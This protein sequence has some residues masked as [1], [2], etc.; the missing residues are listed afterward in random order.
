ME[1]TAAKQIFD[2]LLEVSGSGVSVKMKSR[3]PGGRNVG[4][5]YSMSDHSVTIYL[6]EIKKQCMTLFGSLDGYGQLLR[7][8]FAHE[9]GHAEDAA[10]AD[11]SDR[12]DTCESELERKEI[13]LRIEENAW[14]YALKL[15]PDA[16][17]QMMDT[18]IYYSLH[19]YREAI[20]QET[21]QEIA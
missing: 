3:F 16:D 11:L 1:R 7:I 18:V 10:L 19:A 20:A 13:A 2:E 4:G 6:G 9:L 15:V 21:A 5:K 17:K 8:V 14:E 12:L